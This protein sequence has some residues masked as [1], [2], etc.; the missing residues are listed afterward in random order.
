MPV[1]MSDLLALSD[2][3]RGRLFGGRNLASVD[4]FLDRYLLVTW[5]LVREN[6]KPQ[7]WVGASSYRATFFRNDA[8]KPALDLH[9]IDDNRFPLCALNTSH[10]LGR[11]IERLS[12][13][14]RGH[15]SR[16]KAH[17]VNHLVELV[18]RAIHFRQVSML[19]TF[20]SRLCETLPNDLKPTSDFSMVRKLGDRDTPSGWS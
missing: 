20:I 5:K 8:L 18:A 6:E 13:A 3:H 7:P 1:M 4:R 17:T 11:W 2:M 9:S 16:V 12:V 10:E 15:D 14:A 19:D